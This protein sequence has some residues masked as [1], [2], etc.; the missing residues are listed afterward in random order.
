VVVGGDSV[1]TVDGFDVDA[2]KALVVVGPAVVDT[3]A[4]VAVVAVSWSPAQ[5]TTSANASD[6]TALRI[7]A[8]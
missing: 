1:V 4:A 6:H 8:V 5:A 2:G 7:R 3:V